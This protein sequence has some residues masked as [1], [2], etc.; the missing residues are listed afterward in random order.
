MIPV[1]GAHEMR[2]DEI[3][4]AVV[5]H[6]RAKIAGVLAMGAGSPVHL[7]LV[8]GRVIVGDL[9]RVTDTHA[10]LR[11]WGARSDRRVVIAEIRHARSA[12]FER[13]QVRR[14]RA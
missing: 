5:A 7:V 3:R 13:A 9:V 1:P 14:G 10:V 11:A 8:G 6:E 4:A 2:G 12:Y